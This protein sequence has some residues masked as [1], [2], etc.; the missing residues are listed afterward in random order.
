[1]EG[2]GRV[3]DIER[4]PGPFLVAL[5]GH[6]VRLVRTRI[7]G[8]VALSAFTLAA[9]VGTDDGGE[10]AAPTPP[11]RTPSPSV[12]LGDG[13]G[14]A[15]HPVLYFNLSEED[16]LD[17][18]AGLEERALEALHDGDLGAL[19]DVY[20]SDGPARRKAA[21]TIVREF[22]QNLVDRTKIEVIRTKVLKIRSQMAVFRQVR[23]VYPCIWTYD[24]RFDVTPDHRVVRQ[25]LIRYMAAERLNWRL[26]RDV[27]RREEPTGDRVTACP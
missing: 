16:A 23:L 5:R 4:T 6:R 15:P 11:G 3:W 17:Y 18:L 24:D 12:S 21:A 1:M 27:I 13:L 2:V 19:H 7:A 22:R 9:C 25:V 8:L 20:T 26:H 14:P 10:G